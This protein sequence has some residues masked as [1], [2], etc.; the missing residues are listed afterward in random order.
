MNKI[1]SCQFEDDALLEAH[2]DVE[3]RTDDNLLVEHVLVIDDQESE[4]GLDHLTKM[5]LSSL[6]CN[7]IIGLNFVKFDKKLINF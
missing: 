2:D 6:N 4:V 1:K 5:K 7:A 3:D